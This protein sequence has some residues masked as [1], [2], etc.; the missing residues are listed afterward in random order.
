MA[1]GF[2]SGEICQIFLSGK[3][4]RISNPKSSLILDPPH[5]PILVAAFKLRCQNCSY[6]I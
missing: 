2:L 3:N 5:K 1:D 6:I 4:T